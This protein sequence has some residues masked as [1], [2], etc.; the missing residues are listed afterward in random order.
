MVTP[1][2]GNEKDRHPNCFLK[3]AQQQT[4]TVDGSTVFFKR[5]ASAYCGAPT[6]VSGVP[7]NDN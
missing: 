5:D 6:S 2:S 1:F 3:A 7:Y 4:Q